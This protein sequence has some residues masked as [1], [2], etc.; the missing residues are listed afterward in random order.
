[1]ANPNI[2]NV[3]TIYGNT[4]TYLISSTADP[5]ATA[6]VNNPASSGKVF[7]IN[8]IVVANVDGTNAADITIK[9]FSQD[10]LGGTGT[11]IASTI[12]V[13][14]DATLIITDKTTSFY[15]LEDKS[16]GATA[17]AANDLVVT[18]SWEEINS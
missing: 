3:T 5:F 8:S 18:C 2:V 12:S 10:D 15:L 7:K 9:I 16:I 4:S 6:L 17:S 13:P 11:Q 14:A 1:M